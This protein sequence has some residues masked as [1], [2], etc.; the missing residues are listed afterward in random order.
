MYIF[1]QQYITMLIFSGFSLIMYLLVLVLAPGDEKNSEQG[2]KETNSTNNCQSESKTKIV[3]EVNNEKRHLEKS[4][5]ELK[6]EIGKYESAQKMQIEWIQD[7]INKA[8]LLAGDSFNENVLPDISDLSG[9][10]YLQIQYDLIKETNLKPYVSALNYETIHC[11]TYSYKLYQCLNK[12]DWTEP[13]KNNFLNQKCAEL[14]RKLQ[15]VKMIN[16]GIQTIFDEQSHKPLSGI[17][18]SSRVTMLSFKVENI[19][20]GSILQKALVKPL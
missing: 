7:M 10:I 3:K 16:Y 20:T 4:N 1:Q 17:S 11:L 8:H 13:Q 5:K 2:G 14:N 18:S 9:D 15:Y 6:A 12:T 19:R